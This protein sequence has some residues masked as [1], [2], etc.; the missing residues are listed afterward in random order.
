MIIDVVVYTLSDCLPKSPSLF[1]YTGVGSF[2]IALGV[3]VFIYLHETKSYSA[4][5]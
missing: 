5:T 1:V 2:L 3:C 4:I